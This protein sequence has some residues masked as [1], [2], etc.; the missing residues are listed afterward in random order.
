MKVLFPGAGSTVTAVLRGDPSTGFPGI[1]PPA[2]AIV[3]RRSA[4]ELY[5][6]L[7]SY[8]QKS[9]VASKTKAITYVMEKLAV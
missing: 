6:S 5:L 9:V 7:H 4:P 1:Q 8:E 2:V 3:N